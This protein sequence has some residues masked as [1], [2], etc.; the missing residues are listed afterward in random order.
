MNDHFFNK[1]DSLFYLQTMEHIT[2]LPIVLLDKDGNILLNLGG[3]RDKDLALSQD[4]ILKEDIIK[5]AQDNNIFIYYDIFCIHFGV[6]K[7]FDNNIV[8]IGP[9]TDFELSPGAVRAFSIKHNTAL[10]PISKFDYT[11]LA[12]ILVQINF[13]VTWQ[14]K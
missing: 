6:V 14:K 9:F 13:L 2:S 8:V 3:W 12:A 1:D 11:Q 7:W 5:K 4:K 10:K